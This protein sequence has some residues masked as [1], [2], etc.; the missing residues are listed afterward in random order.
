MP[1]D[2]LDYI[3][4]CQKDSKQIRMIGDG[5]NDA[6]ALKKPMWELRWAALAATLQWMLPTLLW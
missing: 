4:A 1:E 6:L 3:D 5:I 2:K